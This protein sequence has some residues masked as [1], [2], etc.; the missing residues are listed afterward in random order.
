MPKTIE[1]KPEELLARSYVD[2]LLLRQLAEMESAVKL[3]ELADRLQTH[4]VGLAAVRSLLASNAEAFA[5]HERK[6]V[7]AARILG[8]GRPFA[9]AVETALNQFGQ[10]T[11]IDLLAAEVARSRGTE[12]E[13]ERERVQRMVD[14]DPLLSVHGDEV[15]LRTWSFDATDEGRTRAY[16][17]NGVKAED[18][19]ALRAKLGEVDWKNPEAVHKA[20]KAAAPVSIKLLGAVAWSTLNSEDPRSPLVFD[21]AAFYWMTVQTPGIVNAAGMLVAPEDAKKWV[22]VAVKLAD[23]LAPSV[24]VEDAVAIEVKPA[25][26]QR[27]VEKVLSSSTSVTA[28][29]LL[30][31]FYE[32][33]ASNKTFVD[34]LANVCDALRADPKVQWVGGDRFR[35]AG[36]QPDFI[37]ETPEPFFFVQTTNVDE[38]GELVDVELIDDG[39]SSSLRKLIVHPLAMDVLDEDIAPAPKTM[40]EEVRLVLK[41]IHRELGTFPLAQLPTS[42][43]DAQPQTQELIFTDA[44][45]RELEVWMNSETRLMYGLFDWW[46]EQPVESGAVFTLART[47]KPNVFEFAWMDQ[48]DPVVYISSQRMEE[49]RNLGAEHEGESTLKL[50][51]AVMSHWPK[52]ADYLTILAELNVARRASRRLVASLLSSYQCFYQRSGSPVWHFDNKKVD[53]GFDK[54]KKKFIKR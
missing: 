9:Y 7:P 25:D 38:E 6:W 36:D 40:P 20:V 4:G 42:W 22:Q 45:G 37:F 48:P 28:T 13:E 41:S 39:L 35:K 47:S 33:T 18:V 8:S 26:T 16:A 49:L 52:G 32:I 15:A 50:L 19:E 14:R 2:R 54:S 11:P 30:E 53:Q 51:I 43:I 3:S 34:D 17:N 24:D 5:Y 27:M 21:P 10:P 1:L 29:K 31:E 44:A 12:Y 23:K 46:F